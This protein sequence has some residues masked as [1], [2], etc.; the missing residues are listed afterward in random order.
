MKKHILN[1]LLLVVFFSLEAQEVKHNEN[2]VWLTIANKLKVTN[3]LYGSNVVQWRLVDFTKHKRVFLVECG[4]NYKFNALITAGIGYTHADFSL[5]GIRPPTFDDENRFW[6]QLAFSSVLGKF[7][8][9]QRVRFEE[10]H[11]TKTFGAEKYVNR[12]RYRVG[13][14]CKFIKFKN[15]K[16]LLTK[17]SDEIRINFSKGISDPSFNQNNFLAAVGYALL[18]NSKIFLGYGRNYYN[19]SSK[20]YWGDHIVNA[21]LTYD[22][23]FTKKKF[24]K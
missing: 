19:I 7:K 24:Y 12:F 8:I 6:Q 17:V 22:F 5:E 18:S 10:R 9:T 16:Y 15:E 4:V 2:G 23:N 21:L 20:F 3:N 13:L 1:I 14:S 11:L